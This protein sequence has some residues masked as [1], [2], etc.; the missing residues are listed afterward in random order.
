MLGDWGG[1]GEVK[2]LMTE[3]KVQFNLDFQKLWKRRKDAFMSCKSQSV[4]PAFKIQPDR[5]LITKEKH[6]ITSLMDGTTSVWSSIKLFGG[7]NGSSKGPIG[8]TGVCSQGTL[9]MWPLCVR[10]SFVCLTSACGR[11]RGWWAGCSASCSRASPGNSSS[12]NPRRCSPSPSQTG[13][14]GRDGAA[15]EMEEERKRKGVHGGGRVLCILAPNAPL[16]VGDL[17]SD[18]PSQMIPL[19]AH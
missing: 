18:N 14:P 3:N 7:L 17:E 8:N 13:S 15:E 12:C 10:V 19:F 9:W 5:L 4:Y 2:E 11:P 6:K 1:G 16:G